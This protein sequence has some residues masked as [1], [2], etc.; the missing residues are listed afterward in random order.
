MVGQYSRGN[1]SL[2]FPSLSRMFVYSGIH[3][4][5]HKVLTQYTLYNFVY[6]ITLLRCRT[7]H[8]LVVAMQN[9]IDVLIFFL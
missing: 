9:Q 5:L 4:D 7:R 8:L 3:T 2:R 1:F 6:I